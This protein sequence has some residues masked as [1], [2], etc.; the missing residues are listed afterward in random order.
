MHWILQE[1]ED[2]AKPAE[3]LDKRGARYTWHKVVPFVGD[4]IPEPDL[5]AGEPV[6]LFGFYTLWRYAERHG[7]HPGVFRLRPFLH[8]TT[9]QPY[10]L[11]GSNALVMDLRDIPA[12]LPDNGQSWF[13][14]PVE[15]SKEVP[16]S[17]KAAVEIHEI[18]RKVLVLDA[19][20]LPRGSL[21][22]D[23]RIMLCP[24]ASIQKEWRLWIVADRVVTWWLYKE[25]RR[26]T[27]RHEID[28][29]AKAFAE[30]LVAAKSGYAPA[31][32]LDICRTET[33]L[34]MLETNCVN[35]AGFYAADLTHLVDAIETLTA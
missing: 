27:Y 25:G 15:D 8:E 23:T 19:E 16:G 33:G 6:V 29:D 1:F 5:A 14:R 13:F 11:N 30:T 34:R 12:T 21:R 24:P 18:A 20:D 17:V 4:L 26:V 28:E 35:A 10:L 32:V 7:L 31:Y 22:P 3:A 2:T 9:W